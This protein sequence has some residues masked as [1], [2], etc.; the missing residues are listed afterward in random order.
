MHEI[1]KFSSARR[2]LK[3]MSSFSIPIK[4]QIVLYFYCVIYL[5]LSSWWWTIYVIINVLGTRSM[6][7]YKPNEIIVGRHSVIVSFWFLRHLVQ[8]YASIGFVRVHIF[9]PLDMGCVS[10][11]LKFQW[12]S[13][14]KDVSSTKPRE[15][16]CRKRLRQSF[17]RNFWVYSKVFTWGILM[18]SVPQ[19]LSNLIEMLMHV[20]CFVE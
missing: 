19:F 1:V 14:I 6:G 7:Y 18:S 16:H 12:I 9:V 4:N 11:K 10:G 5:F 3:S 8:E 15:I 17:N 20:Y 2:L 13:F